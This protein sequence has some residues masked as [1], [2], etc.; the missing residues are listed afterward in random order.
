MRT[1][2]LYHLTAR[3][4]VVHSLRP[5]LFVPYEKSSMF[6]YQKIKYFRAEFLKL[7]YTKLKNSSNTYNL[8]KNKFKKLSIEVL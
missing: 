2:N 8:V 6:F 4:T 5:K 3:T 1:L 7:F